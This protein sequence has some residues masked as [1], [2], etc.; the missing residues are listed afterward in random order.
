[1]PHGDYP[2]APIPTLPF[3]LITEIL[4]R[5]PVN[6]LMQFNCVCKPWKTLISDP[7]FAKKHLSTVTTTNLMMS[8]M[9]PSREFL[10]RSYSLQSLFKSLASVPLNLNYPLNNRNR[11]DVI[12]GSCDGMI[13]FAIDQNW[14]L[15]W[16]PS[17][18]KF[19]KLPSLDNPKQEGSYTIYG[20]G[21]DHLSDTYKVVGV[22]C[23]ECGNGGAIAYKTQ[24][25]VH[26]LGTDYWRRIQEF[27][28]GVPFDSSGKFVCGAINWLASGSDAFNSS[29]VIVSLDLAKESYEELLQPD[30][31]EV[32]V[33]TLTLGTLKDCL[34]VLAHGDTFSDVWLMK[35]YGNKESWTKL[36]RVPYM[37]N[38]DS[39]PYT[40]AL[41]IS[42]N[43]EVLLECQSTL[44]VYN[45]RNG[46]F[47]V[48]RIQEIGRWA[49]VTEIYV[50]SLISPCS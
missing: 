27:P 47:R 26:T 21:Y 9:N 48:P 44:V 25:K 16:N 19:K 3:E 14:A 37:E 32:D 15:L 2:H 24:V 50:E 10:I 7:K 46:T 22:F 30:Y 39:I 33:V 36:Y 11:F 38:T 5:I 8:F 34:C 45:S 13:C 28:S 20:F 1:M 23:Y 17:I 41:C 35:D 29:W 12:V 42:E 40:K 43:D 6:F 4:S 49:T 31:G 18:R